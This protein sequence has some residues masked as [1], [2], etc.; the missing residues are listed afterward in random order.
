MGRVF[1]LTKRGN[2]MNDYFVLYQYE[3]GGKD[4]F[5][6]DETE[7]ASKAWDEAVEYIEKNAKETAVIIEFHKV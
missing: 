3:S 4:S 5:L 2:T 6:V 7:S 1:H